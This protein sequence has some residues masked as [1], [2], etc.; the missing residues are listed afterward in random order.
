[1][2]SELVLRVDTVCE[3]YYGRALK[4]QAMWQEKAATFQGNLD[5]AHL[6]VASPRVTAKLRHQCQVQSGLRFLRP[7]NVFYGIST[8]LRL[9]AS[10]RRAPRGLSFGC[11]RKRQTR[12][13]SGQARQG[14]SDLNPG[15]GHTDRVTTCGRLLFYNTRPL[16][17]NT[18]FVTIGFTALSFCGRDIAD[19]GSP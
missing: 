17:Y 11:R 15:H 6:L 10:A 9:N 2:A 19:D 18:V 8:Q 12:P 1:M 13:I 7:Q 16:P 5:I 3:E 14:P 4:A